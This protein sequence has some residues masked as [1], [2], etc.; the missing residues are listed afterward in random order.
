MSPVTPLSAYIDAWRRHDVTGVLA[1]LTD[2]CVVIESYGPEYRGLARVEQWMRAW[3]AA[4][5]SVDGWEVTMEA[6]AG[7]VLVAQWRFSCTWK[8]R[9]SAFDGI[10]LARLDGPRIAYLREYATSSPLYDWT[11]EW[12]E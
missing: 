3:F 7:D 5:G 4:G 2:D 8:G 9:S 11:G 6:A 12:R 10:T 1:T